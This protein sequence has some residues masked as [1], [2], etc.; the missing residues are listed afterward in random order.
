[1][2]CWRLEAGGWRLEAG[3]DLLAA[4]YGDLLRAV[5]KLIAASDQ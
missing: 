4:R 1:V 2:T 5:E 3:V